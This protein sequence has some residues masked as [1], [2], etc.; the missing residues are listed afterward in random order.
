MSEHSYMLN[1]LIELA[2]L[3]KHINM[4]LDEIDI[5][6][7]AVTE[8]PKIMGLSITSVFLYDKRRKSVYMAASN[9]ET[10]DSER[11]SR[12]R[13]E[14]GEGLVGKVGETLEP[15]IIEDIEQDGNFSGKSNPKYGDRSCRIL[16]LISGGKLVGVITMTSGLDNHEAAYDDTVLLSL[17]A[18]HIAIAVNN[19]Q[20]LALARD[21]ADRDGLTKLYTHR[22]FH[23]HLDREMARARRYKTKLSL[24]LM[25]VDKFKSVND[26]LGH[27]VGDEVLVGI[28]S[29]ILANMRIGVDIPCRYGGDEFTAILPETSL[30]SAF[31]AAERI[32]R[33][34]D[35]LE[36]KS[37]DESMEVSLSIGICEYKEH[38]SKTEFI[39]LADA[40]MYQ[41]KT[42]GRNRTTR[43][44]VPLREEDGKAAK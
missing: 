2:E 33:M 36:F 35:L 39:N 8:L 29:I 38:L 15:I 4:S 32:R 34:V 31:D 1:K 25:D 42:E 30:D 12:I 13:F 22:Y 16:P 10:I 41:S 21:E 6:N 40:A 20:L 18:D 17:F 14:L 28:S 9:D 19:A 11:M 5:V 43:A 7:Y 23:T 3:S 26:N 24:I 37:I 44:P 27:T